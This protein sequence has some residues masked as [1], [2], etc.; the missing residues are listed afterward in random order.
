MAATA[1]VMD[2]AFVTRDVG[3]LAGTGVR[4]LNPFDAP[5]EGGHR[6]RAGRFVL[7]RSEH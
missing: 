1:K 4:L 2:W 6:T 3:H 5:A 7:R